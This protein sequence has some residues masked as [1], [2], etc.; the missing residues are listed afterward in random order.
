MS[1]QA[2]ALQPL[3]SGVAR[4]AWALAARERPLATWPVFA[5]L[6]TLVCVTPF[7][8]ATS[9]ATL[10]G[11]R[12]SN[13]E[14]VAAALLVLSAVT[15]WRSGRPALT[16]T[17]LGTAWLALV[18][19]LLV[20]AL[21][22]PLN[23]GLATKNVLRLVACG[24]L[25]VAAAAA[26]TTARR[27]YVLVGACLAV[28]ACVAGA[29]ILEARQVDWA[30]RALTA[31]RP[32][33]HVVGGQIRATSTLQ[34]PTIASMHLEIVFA[35]GIGLL[36]TALDCRLTKTTAAIFVAL[37]L[38]AEGIALTFTRAGLMTTL[39]TLA[40]ISALRFRRLG[41]DTGVRLLGALTV[42]SMALLGVS[43]SGENLW[44]RFTTESQAEWYRAAYQVP[45]TL[46]VAPRAIVRV[47]VRVSNEG[48]ITWHPDG[49][50]PF[51][52]SYHWL[53]ADGDRVVQFD[54]LR[55][56]FIDP[57]PPGSTASLQADVEAPPRAGRYRLAWDVVHEQRLWFSTEGSPTA[58]TT[59]EVD[60]PP[61]PPPSSPRRGLPVASHR[62]G[63]LTL[64]R[65]AISMLTAHPLLGVGL[66]NFRWLYASHAGE[67]HFDNRVHANNMFLELL[68]SG[69]LV[70]G[71]ASLWVLT[72]LLRLV[73]RVVTTP[74]G[75]A[76]MAAGVVCALF[77][78][79]LHGVVDSFLTFT[80]S[81]VMAAVT[82]G[83]LVALDAPLARTHAHRV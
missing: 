37:A 13:V 18:C 45:S 16:L 42:V 1:S 5:V 6:A 21:A 77:A 47:P 22:A 67:P 39:G 8:T 55:S 38:V 34:Y 26:L 11:Q 4:P 68:V 57:V 74:G 65:A 24:A 54:G 35:L 59:V 82:V 10:P 40:I 19:A 15:W 61:A 44:L 81:Y 14:L 9:W 7:E 51:F 66:D 41:L 58:I 80:P 36:L 64:W 2:S 28:G 46:A 71:L 69:G 25:A 70:G 56:A 49:D 29:A 23:A 62:P 53:E 52:L 79:L 30:L 3:D 72:E 48:R 73:V 33:I 76:W 12:M 60:G 31:F 32:G 83:L 20:S 78:F 50:P 63:R 27:R 17:G 43:Y 75:E